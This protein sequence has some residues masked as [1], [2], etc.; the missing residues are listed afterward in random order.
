M[1]KDQATNWKKKYTTH[2]FLFRNGLFHKRRSTSLLRWIAPRL[3][4]PCIVKSIGR[5]VL[6]NIYTKRAKSDERAWENGRREWNILVS[7]IPELEKSR[8]LRCDRTVAIIWFVSI[9]N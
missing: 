1:E 2:F 3:R 6:K 9:T 7:Y 4:D 5:P 8:Q